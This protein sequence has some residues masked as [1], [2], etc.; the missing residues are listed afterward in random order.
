MEKCQEFTG[1]KNL[2]FK[3]LYYASDIISL[4][5]ARKFIRIKSPQEEKVPKKIID[6][7]FGNVNFLSFSIIIN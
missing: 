4:G 1:Q 5:I 2:W 7:K 6:E 3:P